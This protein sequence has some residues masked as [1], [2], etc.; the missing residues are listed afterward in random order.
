ML[1]TENPP[2]YLERTFQQW[3]SSSEH[4]L[5]LIRTIRTLQ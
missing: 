1:I 4:A 2:A 3:F 5:G